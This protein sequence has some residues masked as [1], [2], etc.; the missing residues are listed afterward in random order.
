MNTSSPLWR[1]QACCLRGKNPDKAGLRLSF[2]ESI[3]QRRRRLRRRLI[4][5]V[6]RLCARNFFCGTLPPD[7]NC[8]KRPRRYVRRFETPET[9]HRIHKTNLQSARRTPSNNYTCTASVYGIYFLTSMYMQNQL[10]VLQHL[11][12]DV[13]TAH[14][15]FLSLSSSS[16]YHCI[17]RTRSGIYF[18]W[19]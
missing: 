9:C 3:P 11:E 13:K 18:A 16:A 6:R 10:D 4:N 15:P 19:L 7:A 8:Q 1:L 14:S 12:Q 5:Q 2:L 17:I